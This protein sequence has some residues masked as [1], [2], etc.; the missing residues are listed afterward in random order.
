[1]SDT[2]I[3][4]PGEAVSSSAAPAAGTRDAAYAGFWRRVGAAIADGIVVAVPLA[5]GTYFLFPH[6]VLSQ[7]QNPP[8]ATA[9]YLLFLVVYLAVVI[10]YMAGMESS[11]LQA[12]LGKR[13]LKIQVTDLERQRISFLR[14]VKR[15]WFYWLPVA[16]S[17][18]DLL[19]Q[20][21]IFQVIASLFA[22]VSCAAVAFTERRQALHDITAG[23]LVL[24]RPNI[25]G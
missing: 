23:C 20:F 13:L 11:A 1:M 3:S 24:H 4:Q 12:T 5:V 10:A 7:S 19:A 14:A 17:L 15:G 9:S 22:V 18:I 16:L 2:E 25:S 21:M 6:Q 8:E